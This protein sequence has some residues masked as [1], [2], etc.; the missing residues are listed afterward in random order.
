VRAVRA[1][2]GAAAALVPLGRGVSVTIARWSIPPVISFSRHG[3]EGDQGE[4]GEQAFD[5]QI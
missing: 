1:L 5:A 4:I 3:E 2:G